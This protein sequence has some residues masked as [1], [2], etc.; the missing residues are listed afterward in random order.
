MTYRIMS[1][2]G[3]DIG[4]AGVFLSS[5][6]RRVE[7][8]GSSVV[9]NT[10]LYVGTSAGAVAA[11]LLAWHSDPVLAFEGLLRFDDEVRVQGM[12]GQSPWSVTGTFLGTN[13]ALCQ[14]KIR[15]FCDDTFGEGAKL[16]DLKRSVLVT[17][18]QLDDGSSVAEHRSWRPRLFTNLPAD[19]SGD[20]LLA[21][22][23]LRTTAMPIQYPIYQGSQGI[24]PGYV[25]GGVAANN[26]AMMALTH[27]LPSRMLK[28]IALLSI[29]SPR[30]V[31]GKRT[32]LAPDLKDGAA[33]W[34]Y[35]QWLLD[36]FDPMILLDLF[37]QSGVAAVNAQC[38]QLLGAA[39]LRIDPPAVTGPIWNSQGTNEMVDLTVEWLGS[40][41]WNPAPVPAKAASTAMEPV[42]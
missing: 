29:G 27:V 21:D 17:A 14:D 6:E 15:R 11:I 39:Y 38:Q 3:G 41:G 5:L 37:L 25:D 13:A 30:N 23:I 20:E 1:F 33:N 42:A 34:G 10:D 8:L 24:G 22:V 26:P 4:R 40:I 16:S 36:P 7:A 18:V 19:P 12:A 31:L 28:D 2:D 9:K 35:R 32:F